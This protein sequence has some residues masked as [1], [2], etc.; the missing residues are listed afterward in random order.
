MLTKNSYLNKSYC[1]AYI[2][3][4][5]V[6]CHVGQQS[7]WQVCPDRLPGSTG[8]SI[9]VQ[10]FAQSIA[11]SNPPSSLVGEDLGEG[12]AIDLGSGKVFTQADVLECLLV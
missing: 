3:D 2:F 1:H 8:N 5:S 9:A 10:N 7:P 11:T 6:S 4:A 12:H